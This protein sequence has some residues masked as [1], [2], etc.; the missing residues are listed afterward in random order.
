[1]TV[2]RVDGLLSLVLLIERGALMTTTSTTTL[3]CPTTI[4]GVVGVVVAMSVRFFSL[5]L[6]CLLLCCSRGGFVGGNYSCQN[7]H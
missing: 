7:L 3:S 2:P 6:L 1:M 4:Q 5:D